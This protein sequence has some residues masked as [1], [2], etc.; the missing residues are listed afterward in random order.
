M[1]SPGARMPTNPIGHPGPPG[2]PMP[3][4]YRPQGMSPS[5]NPP[6]PR[7]YMTNSPGMGYSSSSPA[8]YGPT[9]SHTSTTPTMMSSPQDTNGGEMQP[10]SMRNMPPGPA[11]M[12]HDQH[13]AHLPPDMPHN[14]PING[15]YDQ[16]LKQSPNQQ[17]NPPP[18]VPPDVSNYSNFDESNTDTN[19]ILK[20]KES[21]Q[22]EVKKFDKTPTNDDFNHFGSVG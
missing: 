9:G 18:P 21:M 12:F 10:Y 4:V 16:Q 13:L 2:V 17:P 3:N 8:P 22:E 1:T 15:E 11:P 19:A 6:G 7:M 5:M 14:T 20:L